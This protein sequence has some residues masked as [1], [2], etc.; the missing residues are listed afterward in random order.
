MLNTLLSIY[1]RE[2]LLINNLS[3]LGAND[4]NL[5]N[6]RSKSYL[7]YIT[8]AKSYPSCSLKSETG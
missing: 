2:L 8:T 4:Q 3:K 5:L 7:A 1:I 6:A